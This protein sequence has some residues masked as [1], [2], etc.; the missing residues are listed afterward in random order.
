[1]IY[2]DVPET[3][4]LQRVLGRDTYIGDETGIREKYERRYFPAERQYVRECRPVEGADWIV[5]F[6]E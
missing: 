4:R 1:V 2:L 3:V 6:E 5:S